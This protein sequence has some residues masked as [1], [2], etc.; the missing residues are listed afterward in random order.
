MLALICLANIWSL[1]CQ[2]LT[3]LK[4]E[5]NDNHD[6]I[7]RVCLIEKKEKAS[8]KQLKSI[9]CIPDEFAENSKF[10]VRDIF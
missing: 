4:G 1:H 3:I 2:H 6:A 8:P 10:I 7:I 9:G 5:S